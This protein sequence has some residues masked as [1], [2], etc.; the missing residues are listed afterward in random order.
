MEG[1]GVP[2]PARVSNVE[3]KETKKNYSFYRETQEYPF[4]HV[5]REGRA[6]LSI[7]K[8]L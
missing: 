6:F 1:T 2:K 8:G 4:S 5:T 3:P 7:G